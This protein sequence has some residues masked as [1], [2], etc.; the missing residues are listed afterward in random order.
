M[1]ATIN[2][3]I[4]IL[5]WTSDLYI[6]FP[7]FSGLVFDYLVLA[8]T[9]ITNILLLAIVFIL[10]MYQLKKRHVFEYKEHKKSHYYFFLVTFIAG[11]VLMY[12]ILASIKYV[13]VNFKTIVN[14]SMKENLAAFCKDY[15]SNYVIGILILDYRPSSLLCL[16]NIL[17][18]KKIDDV[19]QGIN[20]LDHLLKVSVF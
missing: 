2:C 18:I 14:E 13:N 3:P 1:W 9:F 16:Y 20:K 11:L 8:Y 4:S 6:K 15:L 17:Y 5:L 19:L 12:I 10:L 7:T